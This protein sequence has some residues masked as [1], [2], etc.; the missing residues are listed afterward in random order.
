M[1]SGNLIIKRQAIRKII[2]TQVF[3]ISSGNLLY[4]LDTC[5]NLGEAKKIDKKV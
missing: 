3:D 5:Q 1:D 4:L 2:L